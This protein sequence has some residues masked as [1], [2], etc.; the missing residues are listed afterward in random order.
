M[1]KRCYSTNQNKSD[2]F[3]KHEIQ[4]NGS[5]LFY[6]DRPWKG[7]SMAVAHILR[8]KDEN[9]VTINLTEINSL[10][11]TLFQMDK[12]TYDEIFSISE[13]FETMKDRKLQK[14]KVQP[15][16]LLRRKMKRLEMKC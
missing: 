9:I 8:D 13:H 15:Q 5:G 10:K 3:L 1:T 4:R 12:E 2:F 11:E 16:I 14:K 6:E 7:S